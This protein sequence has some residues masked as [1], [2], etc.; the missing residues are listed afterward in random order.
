MWNLCSQIVQEIDINSDITFDLASVEFHNLS[1]DLKLEMMQDGY[2]VPTNTNMIA[3][4][5]QNLADLFAQ[6]V[7]MVDRGPVAPISTLIW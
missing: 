3:H 6:A 1:E 5:Y 4:Q 2:S 7:V